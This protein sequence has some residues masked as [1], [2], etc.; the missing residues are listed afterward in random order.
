M[1]NKKEIDQFLNKKISQNEKR[2]HSLF[3]S[4]LKQSKSRKIITNPINNPPPQR[5]VHHQKNKSQ[6]E[7]YK[8][9]YNTNNNEVLKFKGTIEKHPYSR[10]IEN[11]KDDDGS[12]AFINKMGKR[13]NLKNKSKEEEE[14]NNKIFYTTFNNIYQKLK[15]KKNK[16]V[17]NKGQLD[18]IVDRL[19][20]ND[21][22]FKKQPYK[23]IEKEKET[24]TIDFSIP[25]DTMETPKKKILNNRML[26]LMK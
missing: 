19:Y 20:N 2:I 5:N 26:T 9:S 16:K 21:Y 4:D 23:E 22:K 15:N 12:I 1:R 25:T 18:N 17:Y 11:E 24:S 3:N 10:T 13:I 8:N 7:I 14:K 6:D